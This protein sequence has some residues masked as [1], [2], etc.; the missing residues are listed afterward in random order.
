M[1][2][3]PEATSSNSTPRGA[4]TPSGVAPQGP[5]SSG[6]SP[7]L[8]DS[9]PPTGLP[10][11][12]VKGAARG[13]KGWTLQPGWSYFNDGAGFHIAV[14]DGWTYQRVGTTYCFRSP[15]NAR[16]MSLDAGRDPAVDPLTAARA[17]D[18]RLAR[19]KELPGYALIGIVSV[20]L[21]HK[22]AD[23]EY[24]YQA[25]S[26]AVRHAGVRWFVIDGRAYALG[27]S[28]PEKNWSPDLSKIQMIRGTFFTSR[29]ALP[30]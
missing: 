26:G 13:V 19:S 22:A 20:P 1:S 23:W 10:V 2:A 12:P 3:G 28:T 5:A 16:V 6:F 30:R 14:P 25:R 15:R 29:S 21:L 18:Q 24:R 9:P 27:W 8:C 11:T 17:E 7:V 4:A